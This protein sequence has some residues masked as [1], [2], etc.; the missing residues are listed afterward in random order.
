VWTIDG[1]AFVSFRGGMRPLLH[2]GDLHVRGSLLIDDH[3][4]LICTGDLIVDG[5][6][7]DYVPSTL[8]VGGNL[9]ARRMVTNGN[10]TVGGNARVTEVA[11]ARNPH[12]P[13]RVG[14]T[15]TARNLLHLGSNVRASSFDVERSIDVADEKDVAFY[16]ATLSPELFAGSGA[17]DDDRCDRLLRCDLNL[18]V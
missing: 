14:E 15:Y 11:F 4:W 3:A 2:H 18:F 17:I 12:T 13:A 5:I 1:D 9:S 8:A 6:I 16:R 10:L 7:S